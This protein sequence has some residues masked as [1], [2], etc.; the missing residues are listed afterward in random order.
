M[1]GSNMNMNVADG[2]DGRQ[3]RKQLLLLFFSLLTCSRS[4]WF[5]FSVPFYK[6]SPQTRYLFISTFFFLLLLFFPFLSSPAFSRTRTYRD[7]LFIDS[8]EFNSNGM[9][10]IHSNGIESNLAMLRNACR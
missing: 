1:L 2:R 5:V 8:I 4:H 3:C 6:R 9:T 7:E 10:L